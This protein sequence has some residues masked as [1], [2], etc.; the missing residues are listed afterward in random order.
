MCAVLAVLCGSAGCASLRCAAQASSTQ[1]GPRLTLVVVSAL[2]KTNA[3]NR[4]ESGVNASRAPC[5]TVAAGGCRARR[6]L[7][8]GPRLHPHGTGG[9]RKGITCA[10]KPA[11]VACP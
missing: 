8:S 6:G 3:E 11:V 9:S 4:M 7:V 1:H 5:M 10:H 2:K